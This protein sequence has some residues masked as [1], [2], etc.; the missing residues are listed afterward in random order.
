M[1]NAKRHAKRGTRNCT[2]NW[3]KKEANMSQKL[4]QNDDLLGRESCQNRHQKLYNQLSE[5]APNHQRR[6]KDANCQTIQ[7]YWRAIEN[8]MTMAS[9]DKVKRYDM[10]NKCHT[11]HPNKILDNTT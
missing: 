4:D 6:A 10:M 3:A 1:Q 9:E 8:W 7:T 5:R 2:K 11:W